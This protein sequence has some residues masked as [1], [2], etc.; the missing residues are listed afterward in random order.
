MTLFS[1]Q[2]QMHTQSS[3]PTLSLFLPTPLFLV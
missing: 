1:S 2:L 3:I